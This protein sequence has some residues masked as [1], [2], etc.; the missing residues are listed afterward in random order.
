M[1]DHDTLHV[2]QVPLCQICV[3]F[4]KFKKRFKNIICHFV[5]QNRRSAGYYEIMIGITYVGGDQVTHFNL[6][7]YNTIKWPYQPKHRP[8]LIDNVD[9]ASQKATQAEVSKKNVSVCSDLDQSLWLEAYNPTG[10]E[11]RGGEGRGGEGRG[12][13]G[14]EGRGGRGGEGGREGRDDRYT[15]F[16]W[17][18]K[19][20]SIQL[21]M[22]S[23]LK[24]LIIMVFVA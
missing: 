15:C 18:E 8:S 19:R 12:G 24:S 5:F 2:C 4:I 1:A 11:G 3:K 16:Y 6:V 23:L 14:R 20:H 21:I 17:S 10:G 13:E 9:S 22:A 7:L